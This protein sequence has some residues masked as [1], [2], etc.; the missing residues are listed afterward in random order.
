[1]EIYLILHFIII[2]TKMA[3]RV[4]KTVCVTLAGILKS[5]RTILLIELKKL[6]IEINKLVVEL[7]H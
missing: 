5:F 6:L 7:R 1:V 3:G 4:A 2:A